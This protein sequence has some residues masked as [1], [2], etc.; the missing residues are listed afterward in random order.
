MTTNTLKQYD[1]F[2]EQKTRRAKSIG[3]EPL[4]IIAPLFDWQQHVVNWAVTQGRAALFEDC[5]LG[6]TAQQLEWSSQVLRYTGESVLILTPLAVAHQTQQEGDLVFSP[7]TG[8]GSELKESYFK[9][10]VQNLKNAKSQLS[11][12]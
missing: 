11:L 9:Q 5:G 10:A 8:I 3:F 4:P 1:E 12:F 7:F 2:I 6:K